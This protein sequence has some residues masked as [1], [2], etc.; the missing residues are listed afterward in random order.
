MSVG[1]ARFDPGSPWTMD[2]LL[3][4]ADRRLYRDKRSRQ[5]APRVPGESPDP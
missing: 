1:V 2:R 5:G 4:E 3:E